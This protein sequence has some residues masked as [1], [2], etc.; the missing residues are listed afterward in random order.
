MWVH[1]APH[2]QHLQG[3]GAKLDIGGTGRGRCGHQK[4]ARNFCQSRESGT[5][6]LGKKSK[7]QTQGAASR[8]KLTAA[9]AQVLLHFPTTAQRRNMSPGK[10]RGFSSSSCCLNA[11]DM[12][13]KGF[14]SKPFPTTAAFLSKT[15][16]IPKKAEE[17]SVNR[18]K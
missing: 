16:S 13:E 8:A 4:E 14:L 18:R 1:G 3:H 12:P 5:A 10:Y 7:W 2:H 11:E 6:A 17:D 9:V 15:Q